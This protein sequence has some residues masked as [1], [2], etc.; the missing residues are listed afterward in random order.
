MVGAQIARSSMLAVM[1]GVGLVFSCSSQKTA[2]APQG[3]PPAAASQSTEAQSTDQATGSPQAPAVLERDP[4]AIAALRRMGEFLREQRTFTVSGE[5]STDEVLDTGQKIQLESTVEL[6]ARRPDRLRVDIDSDRK[7]RSLYYDGTTFTVFG[8]RVGY[9]AQVPAPPTIAETIEQIQDR[10][11][12]SMPLVDLFYWG[13][14]DS[15]EAAIVGAVDIG[16][17]RVNGVDTEH[18]VFRQADVDFQLWIETGAKPL[19]RKLVIT[20]LSEPAQPQHS[21]LMTWN[22]SPELDEAE[23]RFVPPA[24]AQRIVFQAAQP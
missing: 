8:E 7:Q 18:Y 21:V 22:L 14:K 15:D 19:P 5:T 12:I 6:K 24:G 9:Y 1:F 16:P 4:K 3:M 11:G 20:T 23:F 10:L 2:E 17:S 13:T